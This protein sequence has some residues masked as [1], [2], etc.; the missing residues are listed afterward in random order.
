MFVSFSRRLLVLHCSFFSRGTVCVILWVN[1]ESLFFHW[2]CYL[3]SL[4][5]FAPCSSSKTILNATTK[6]RSMGSTN[7]ELEKHCSFHLGANGRSKIN[8][9]SDDG[10][11]KQQHCISC[12]NGIKLHFW[13]DFVLAVLEK[14]ACCIR[15][16][17][18]IYPLQKR[19]A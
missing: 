5:D 17:R 15:E 16:D 13:S 14:K 18:H 12:E 2:Y 8:H 6:Q 3:I 11:Y 10:M 19:N 9:F 4:F 1:L 7:R